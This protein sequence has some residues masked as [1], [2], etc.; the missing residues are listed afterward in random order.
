MVLCPGNLN[1][2]GSEILTKEVQGG[3][4]AKDQCGGWPGGVPGPAEQEHG[5]RLQAS[6]RFSFESAGPEA[7]EVDGVKRFVISALAMA[8]TPPRHTQ[9][10][11]S[12]RGTPRQRL[13]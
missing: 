6:G 8:V 9:A 4:A 2:V 1:Q 13:R 3:E 12:H 10:G 11:E 5:P 7:L